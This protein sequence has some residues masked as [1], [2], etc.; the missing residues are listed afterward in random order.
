MVPPTLELYLQSRCSAP[1]QR[2][3]NPVAAP[4]QFEKPR[5]K[6]FEK[7]SGPDPHKDSE[8]KRTFEAQKNAHPATL[9]SKNLL[10]ENLLRESQ[11]KLDKLENVKT[12]LKNQEEKTRLRGSIEMF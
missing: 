6:L 2:Q 7:I 9:F 4:F 11:G 12:C 10:R 1:Q 5:S 8:A 3:V